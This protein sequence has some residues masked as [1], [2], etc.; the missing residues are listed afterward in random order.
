MRSLASVPCLRV[1][2]SFVA[3]LVGPQEQLRSGSRMGPLSEALRSRAEPSRAPRGPPPF[4]S[5][6]AR[7]TTRSR[8]LR[9]HAFRAHRE[10]RS[11]SRPQR[12]DWDTRSERRAHRRQTTSRS[13][14]RRRV[15]ACVEPS[16]EALLTHTTA[17]AAIDDRATSTMRAIA[18]RLTARGAAG[19]HGALRPRS[20]ASTASGHGVGASAA[21]PLSKRAARSAMA[22]LRALRT[23]ASVRSAKN[24]LAIFGRTLVEE[25]TQRGGVCQQLFA[26]PQCQLRLS[27]RAAGPPIVHVS[28]ADLDWASGVECAPEDACAGVTALPTLRPPPPDFP[29]VLV[30]DAVSD[31]GNL[32]SLIRSA[33]AFDFALVLVGPNGCDSFNDKVI[34]SSMGAALTARMFKCDETELRSLIKRAKP[35]PRVLVTDVH[36][37]GSI[38]LSD[39]SPSAS[40]P[41]WLVIGSESHGVRSSLRTL[42]ARLHIPMHGSRMESLNAAVAGAICMQHV[43]AQHDRASTKVQS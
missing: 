39:V 4:A 31:P 3:R 21:I 17:I 25:W 11:G 8:L 30:L 1:A 6:V 18:T 15:C 27:S 9:P 13:L 34:R 26:A 2:P 14:I 40:D 42:G 36:A 23:D 37:A 35:T 38:A 10:T 22:E 19:G 33:L 32:G 29:R 28:H 12:P 7:P 16:S 43:H 20:F 41:V 5:H 24:Q